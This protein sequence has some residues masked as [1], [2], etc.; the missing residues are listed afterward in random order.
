[1]E[2]RHQITPPPGEDRQSKWDGEISKA[3]HDVGEGIG[4]EETRLPQKAE[5]MWGE[6]RGIQKAKSSL[7][8]PVLRSRP[9][10][11]ILIKPIDAYG[12]S[13]LPVPPSRWCSWRGYPTKIRS[14]VTG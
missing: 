7:F 1:M 8:S 9:W 2:R 11:G 12:H 4:P 13:L 10:I 14:A 6:P 3:D 5:P